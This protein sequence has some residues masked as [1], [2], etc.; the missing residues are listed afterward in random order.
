ML[1]ICALAGCR[2]PKP[3]SVALSKEEVIL[4]DAQPERVFTGMLGGEPVHLVT[5][6][7]VVYMI[8]DDTEWEKVLEPEFYPSF[9]LCDRQ[10]LR[11]DGDKVIATLGRMAFGA[12]GCCASGGTYRTTDGRNWQK[13]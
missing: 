12:G 9:M 8:K 2:G 7:C 3:A 1:I 5:H 4:R 10:S 11:A 13:F 6:D